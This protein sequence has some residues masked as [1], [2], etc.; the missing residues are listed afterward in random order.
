VRN[1][2]A[3]QISWLGTL[4]LP[5]KN[6]EAISLKAVWPTGEADRMI[7]PSMAKM[8]GFCGYG[9]IQRGRLRNCGQ[10]FDGS[11]SPNPDEITLFVKQLG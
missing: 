1:P 8:T 6:T 4:N 10:I 3:G 7:A 5:R 9:L 2:G 11:G